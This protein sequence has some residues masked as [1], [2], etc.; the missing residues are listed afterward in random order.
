MIE[1]DRLRLRELSLDDTEFVLE[2][3]NTP[4]WIRYIGDKNVRTEEQARDYLENG[5]IKSYRENGYGLS[6]V[7]EKD[8]K[9]A[10]GMCGILKRDSLENPDIGYAFLPE[11]NGRGYAYEIA[12]ATLAYARDQLHI[13]TICAI[14]LTDNKRSIALMEKIGLKFRQKIYRKEDEEE[15]LLYST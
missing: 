6:L 3:L 5:P 11:F 9:R 1:T 4:G 12:S 2:L 15:L 13:P 14:T 7:E 10:I 8:G